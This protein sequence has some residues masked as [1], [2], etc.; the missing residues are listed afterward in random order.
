MVAKYGEIPTGPDDD[1]QER[2][3]WDLNDNVRKNEAE[4][5]VHLRGGFA[6]FE[7]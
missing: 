5:A 1:G 2:L 6:Q 4:P 3:V 7:Q